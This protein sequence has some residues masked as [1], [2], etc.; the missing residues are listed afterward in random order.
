MAD[1][2]H[3]PEPTPTDAT[4][5]QRW[6]LVLGE[7][8][9]RLGE[10][11]GEQAQRDRALGFLYDREST[12]DREGGTRGGDGPSMLTVPQ[13]VN[14]VHTLFP[15]QTIDLLQRDA[16]ERYGMIELVTDEQL[17]DRVEP[18]ETLL[19]AVL[20]TK[21]LMSDQVL[22][23]A[24]QLVR[25]VVDDL[26]AR[27]R[28]RI[29][30]A[31]TG[32][33]H[34]HR[35]SRFKVAS[36]FD[37]RATIRANLKH[38]DPAT[39]RLVI[40]EPLFSA[41]T[42]RES[43]RWQVIIAVDQSGSMLDSVIHSAVTASVFGSIP[44]LRCHLVAFDTEVVDLTSDAADPVETLMRV[45]LGGGTDI[46]KAVRY[47]AQLVTE[48]RRAMVVV[49]TDLYEGAAQGNLVSTVT[50]LCQQGTRVLV[51]GALTE[52]GHSDWDK[53]LG[54]RL[55]GVGAQVGAMTPHH[56]AEWVAEAIR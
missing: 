12:A 37:P 35:R 20:A 11:T 46:G 51:L 13:W 19:K 25:R 40:R 15:R 28:P 23:A 44:A 54:A 18:S 10:L 17:L 33:R 48:P 8:S 47:C 56:L 9:E 7:G 31:L 34:P 24:R 2:V 52:D 53:A 55:Q 29:R 14:D 42:V 1:P 5:R 45:Q 4:R 3:N 50:Q 27:M 49:I 32:R 16:L 43:E 38:V 21:H 30:M 39:G 22:A 36:N 26:V 6:R 41:R